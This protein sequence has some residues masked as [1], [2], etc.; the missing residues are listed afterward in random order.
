ML[1]TR[2]DIAYAV[3]KLAQFA[4]NPSKEHLNQAHYVIHYLAG[5]VNYA[6][7]FN[8][9][10]NKGLI[11]YTDSDYAADPIKHR[12][13]TGFLFKLANGIIS[14]QSRAQKTMRSQPLKLNTWRCPTAVDKLSGFKIYSLNWAYQLAQ[15]RFVRI[16][17]AVYL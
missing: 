6:L 17:K 9:A 5:T 10:S 2:P 7:V 14:W 16:M 13:T 4:A 11:A 1:R 12:S 8:G 15:L 3:T